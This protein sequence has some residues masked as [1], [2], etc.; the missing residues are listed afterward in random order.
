MTCEE[1]ALREDIEQ[2]LSD[3]EL[4]NL[5]NLS[6]VLGNK[7]VL[8]GSTVDLADAKLV[9]KVSKQSCDETIAVDL[10]DAKLLITTL[11]TPSSR[12]SMTTTRPEGEP[13]P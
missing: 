2:G 7:L 6:V 10:A 12:F 4:L 9:E 1:Q 13:S 3:H 11:D 8:E 5:L